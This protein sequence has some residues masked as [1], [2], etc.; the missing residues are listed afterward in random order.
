LGIFSSP[1]PKGTAVRKMEVRE[2]DNGCYIITTTDFQDSDVV[3]YHWDKV[4][5][6]FYGEYQMATLEKRQYQRDYF[7]FK[8]HPTI[9]DAINFILKKDYE[10][11]NERFR[12]RCSRP[13]VID[14]III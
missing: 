3:E 11:M 7:E 6:N 5:R 2:V 14:R 12:A 1:S 9:G 4:P 10:L 8:D 13:R